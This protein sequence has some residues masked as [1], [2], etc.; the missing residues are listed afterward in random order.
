MNSAFLD[1]WT[2]FEMTYSKKEFKILN[3]IINDL[4][5]SKKIVK[6]FELF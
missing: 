2:I 5:L 6:I 4:Q 1:R 3:S